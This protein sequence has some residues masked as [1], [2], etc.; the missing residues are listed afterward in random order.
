[1]V[2]FKWGGILYLTN[3][4]VFLSYSRAWY[5]RSAIRPSFRLLI[6]FSS[7]N[8]SVEVHFSVAVIVG[9]MKPCIVIV[10]GTLFKHKPWPY[11]INIQFM[12]HWLQQYLLRVVVIAASIKH[13][14]ESVFKS[15]SSSKHY[16]PV[17]LT[18]ISRSNNFIKIYVVQKLYFESR[19][20]VHF[21]AAK[22]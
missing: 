20:E 14:I 16:D 18:Y 8:N 19:N 2:F 21:S 3:M 6:R 1:M 7:V 22:L 13:C 5:K 12:L 15:H 9:S 17:P 11:A 10:I 4:Y